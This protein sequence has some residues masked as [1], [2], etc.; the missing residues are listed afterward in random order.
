M[1]DRTTDTT[2][3]VSLNSSGTQGNR[4]FILPLAS[5][6]MGAMWR[7]I[8][9]ASNLVSGD[10]NGGHTDVFVHDRNTEYHNTCLGEIHRECKGIV[11]H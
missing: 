11:I 10:T 6:L 8:L 9:T 5:H 7:L 1:H 2:T 3:R 4:R